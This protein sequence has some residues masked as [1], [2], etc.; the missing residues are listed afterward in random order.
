MVFFVISV[1]MLTRFDIHQVLYIYAA[2]L[3]PMLLYPTLTIRE[4]SDRHQCIVE[5]PQLERDE[6]RQD[7]SQLTNEEKIDSVTEHRNS[8]ELTANVLADS[9]D[10]NDHTAITITKEVDSHMADED[11]ADEEIRQFEEGSDQWLIHHSKR[12]NIDIKCLEKNLTQ[13]RGSEN[14]H[15]SDRVL[16]T[17][18]TACNY[19]RVNEEAPRAVDELVEAGLDDSCFDYSLDT[20][21]ILRTPQSIL[22]TVFFAAVLTPG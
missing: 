4:F 7:D 15:A 19:D 6:D 8:E 20:W 12:L 21:E 16:N 5:K 14:A 10:R 17:K 1:P 2:V 22:I 18:D 3:F 9:C 13:C 11:M